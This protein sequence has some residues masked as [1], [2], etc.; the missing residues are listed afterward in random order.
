MTVTVLTTDGWKM[1]WHR[2]ER[3]FA[4][5]GKVYNDTELYDD[6]IYHFFQDAWHLKDWIKNDPSISKTVRNSI[7][8]EVKNVKPLRIAADI[9]NGTK[10]MELKKPRPEKALL[11]ER[12]VTIGLSN[13]S[14]TATHDLVFTLA[15]G[16]KVSAKDVAADV[17]REWGLLLKKLGLI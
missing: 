17:M 3:S 8:D 5:L 11:T 6:D 9:A 12:N 1:Q 16:S 14:A 4:K 2:V 7:E 10:H 15:D 13:P